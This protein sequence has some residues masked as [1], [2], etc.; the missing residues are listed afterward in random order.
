MHRAE[1]LDALVSHIPSSV[2]HFGK[3]LN[4]LEQGSPT[5]P[6]RL[7]FAD[8]SE[9]T[10]DVVIGADGIHSTVRGALG[11]EQAGKSAQS[12]KSGLVWSGTWAYR[13]LIPREK[14]EAA[15]GKNGKLYALTP[16]MVRN[17]HAPSLGYVTYPGLP[18]LWALQFLG[19]D[20]V[21]LTC[22]ICVPACAFALCYTLS[23]L[24][25]Y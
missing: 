25:H 17:V 10:A 7:F 2:A 19:L 15:V 18:P 23:S 24:H 21:R 12:G 6:V 1:F 14:F 9:A 22:S 11:Q 16:Q 8:G 13:G 4:R 3:R 5:E 20:K